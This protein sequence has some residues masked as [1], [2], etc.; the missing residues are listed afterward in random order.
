[1]ILKLFRPNPRRA[2]VAELY[3]RLATAA[4]APALYLGLGVPDTLEGR[5][6]ALSLHVILA[7]RALRALPAPAD[8]AARDLTDAFFRDL[9][10]SLREMGVG[11]TTVPKRMKKLAEAFYGRA[12]AYDLALGAADASALAAALGRNVQGH[13]EGGEAQAVPLA[14]YA[15]AADRDLRSR[16][17]DT[18]FREGFGFPKPESF[19]GESTTP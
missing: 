1:M 17:L 18:I 4:R 9:D 2:A 8:E 6:E 7:L 13:V 5:F 15:I 12:Q 14:R 16:D 3:E 11:D 10:G 19:V